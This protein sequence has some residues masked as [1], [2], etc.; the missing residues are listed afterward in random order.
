MSL[1]EEW[2]SSPASRA[3]SFQDFCRARDRKE[4][5]EHEAEALAAL[6]SAETW[7]AIVAKAERAKDEAEAQRAREQ[8]ALA[9]QNAQASR[10][11]AAELRRTS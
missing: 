10:D 5:D 6:K 8:A 11:K 7:D 4:A 3:V 2:R 9:R 1:H